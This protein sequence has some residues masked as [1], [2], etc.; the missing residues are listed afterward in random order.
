M[1][2]VEA[3]SGGVVFSP[4]SIS[5]PGSLPHRGDANDGTR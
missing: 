1:V 2:L 4:G 5:Y 3:P